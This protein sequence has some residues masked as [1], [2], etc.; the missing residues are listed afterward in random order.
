LR[1]ASRAENQVADFVG[2]AQHV[3]QNR[4]EI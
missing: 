2:S 1:R 3:A 4:H